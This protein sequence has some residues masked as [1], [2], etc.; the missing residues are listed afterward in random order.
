M[1]SNITMIFECLI[2]FNCKSSK[3]EFSFIVRSLLFVYIVILTAT[4]S[5][6]YPVIAQQQTKSITTPSTQDHIKIDILSGQ[7]LHGTAG[8][9]VKIEGKIT[10][11]N[12]SSGS[13]KNNESGID[14]I[15]IVDVKDRVPVDLEDWSVEKGLYIPFVER[16]HSLPLEWSVRLVKAGSYTVTILFNSNADPHA[17]PVASSRIIMDVIPK[18]N[19]N[20][21]NILPVAFSVPA[22]LMGIFG[23]LN[24]IRG[25]KTG[26]YK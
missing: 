10:N 22:G 9:F 23:T 13:S 11:L 26:I 14:Y 24:Y 8:Q 5:L 12:P 1:I 19:L 18:L 7:T 15:S 25:R 3:P 2:R 17:P 16:G 20:P 6:P 4:L 21:G